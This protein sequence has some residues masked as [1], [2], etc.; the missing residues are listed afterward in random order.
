M[1]QNL[2]DFTHQQ[3]VVPAVTLPPPHRATGRR[4]PNASLTRL[5]GGSV[6][7]WNFQWYRRQAVLQWVAI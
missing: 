7:R 2:H 3:P 1:L 6:G 5:A 4:L